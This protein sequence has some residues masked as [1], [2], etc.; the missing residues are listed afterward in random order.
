M[1]TQMQELVCRVHEAL[2]EPWNKG[3]GRP[4]SCGLYAAVEID[5]GVGETGE[6][7]HLHRLTERAP[8]RAA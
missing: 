6:R 2:A 4:K 8:E 1:L 5:H 7:S 3:V